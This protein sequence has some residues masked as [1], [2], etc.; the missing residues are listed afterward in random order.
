MNV[1]RVKGYAED[2]NSKEGQQRQP[3][4]SPPTPWGKTVDANDE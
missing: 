1:N 4:A 3:K 2:M